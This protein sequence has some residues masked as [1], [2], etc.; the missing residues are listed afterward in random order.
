MDGAQAQTTSRRRGA[1]IATAASAE[2]GVA[3]AFLR[4]RRGKKID[5]AADSLAGDVLF[6]LKHVRASA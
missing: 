6:G 5:S 3:L 1:G 2:L 4:E